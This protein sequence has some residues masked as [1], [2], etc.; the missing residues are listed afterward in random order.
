MGDVSNGAG[1]AIYARFSSENQREASIDDQIRVC[2]AYL[3][4]DGRTV[5]ETYA[6]YAISGATT[7]R[8]GYQALLRDARTKRFDMI[9]AKSLDRF[10]RDQEQIAAFYKQ[11]TFAGVSIVTLAEGE[12][13]EL[14]VG[15]KGTM[16]ALYLKGL[17]AK[18]PSGSGRQGPSGAQCEW[19]LLWLSRDPSVSGRRHSAYRHACDRRG[20][21]WSL[22]ARSAQDWSLPAPRLA[23]IR[24]GALRSLRRRHDGRWRTWPSRMRQSSRTGHMHQSP[25][26]PFAARYWPGYSSD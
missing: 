3:A 6:D 23:A 18:D 26:R 24:A 10:S 4:R 25:D 7:L 17:G 16:S 9:V 19:P 2:T 13:T 1:A 11:M 8:P 14:H 22:R 15:L 12:I 21:P 5:V 20:A